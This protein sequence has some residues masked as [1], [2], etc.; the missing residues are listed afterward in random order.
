MDS[1]NQTTGF[2]YNSSSNRMSHHSDDES[3]F[4]GIL[5]IYVHHARNFHNICIY[6]NQ[7]VY[8]KFSLAYNPDETL[9]TRIIKGS[10]KNPDFN[11]NLRLKITKVDAVQ[12]CEIWMLS[13]ARNYLE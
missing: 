2:R 5:D 7:D 13:R 12:T 3:E 9:S 11:E 6:D 1:F 4:S 8:A 10:G